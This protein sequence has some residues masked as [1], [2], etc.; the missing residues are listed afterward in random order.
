[1][2]SPF[3]FF[4]V[5]RNILWTYVLPGLPFISI[6]FARL[7][8]NP[9][10][11]VFREKLIAIGIIAFPLAALTMGIY[12]FTHPDK[13]KSTYAPIQAYQLATQSQAGKLF[14]LG[15]APFSAWYY[16]RRD[17]TE[18]TIGEIEGNLTGTSRQP[19]ERQQTNDI[20]NTGAYIML[21]TPDLSEGGVKPQVQH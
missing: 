20:G 4:T 15:K 3:L 18:T 5:S 8:V 10:A 14:Y 6:L 19:H 12:Y 13:L 17:L 16:T 21:S 11:T 1:M 9:Q 7:L 2:L